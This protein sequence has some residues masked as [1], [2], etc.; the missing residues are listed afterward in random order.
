[1]RYAEI[2]DTGEICV[3]KKL[4]ALLALCMLSVPMTACGGGN[5]PT[6]TTT[7]A[8]TTEIKSDE[9]DKT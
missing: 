6:E 5:A 1:M 8:Q 9:K 4:A 2:F 3:K 7:A